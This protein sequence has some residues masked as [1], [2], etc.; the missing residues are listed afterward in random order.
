MGK[1]SNVIK[2]LNYLNTGNKYSVK[3]LANIINVKRINYLN[4]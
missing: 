4:Y 2:M 1:I 3:E